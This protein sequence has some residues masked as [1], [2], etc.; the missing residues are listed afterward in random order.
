MRRYGLGAF[1]PL[2]KSF[3]ASSSL[4]EP[5]MITSW[6]CFQFAGVANG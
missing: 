1:Q 3:F 2:G 4:T 5:A 6:P